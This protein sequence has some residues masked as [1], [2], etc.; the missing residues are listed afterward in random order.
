MNICKVLDL[1]PGL[2]MSSWG[3]IHLPDEERILEYHIQV[4]G[5][6]WKSLRY[7]SCI[8]APKGGFEEIKRGQEEMLAQWSENT[9]NK[10]NVE[11]ICKEDVSMSEL[12]KLVLGELQKA[13]FPYSIE[14]EAQG[15]RK[16]L[17]ICGQVPVKKGKRF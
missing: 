10:I 12:L 17:E 1:N 4:E 2:E 6:I 16:R 5:A 13:A 9:G 15:L 11:M 14:K 7:G 3:T 8:R